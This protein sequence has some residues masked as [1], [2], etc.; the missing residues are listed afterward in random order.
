MKDATKETINFAK[1][2]SIVMKNPELEGKLDPNL[3]DTAIKDPS[4]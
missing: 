2:M 3:F 1:K 4:E